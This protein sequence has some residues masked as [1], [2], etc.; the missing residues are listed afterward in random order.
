MIALAV[1]ALEG[2]VQRAA[3]AGRDLGRLGC[4]GAAE[5]E[6]IGEDAQE[7]DQAVQLA[8]PILHGVIARVDAQGSG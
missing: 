4:A 8:H 1:I 3:V 6:G 5:V 7:P 2:V